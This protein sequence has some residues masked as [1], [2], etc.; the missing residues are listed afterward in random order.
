MRLCPCAFSLLQLQELAAA[1]S[2]G[3]YARPPLA[4]EGPFAHAPALS[5]QQKHELA[6]FVAQHESVQKLSPQQA[7]LTA[8]LA[9]STATYYSQCRTPYTLFKSCDLPHSSP[10]LTTSASR[11]AIVRVSF[12]QNGEQGVQWYYGILRFFAELC[13]PQCKV[14]YVDYFARAR[15][16][17][18]FLVQRVADKDDLSVRVVPIENLDC[19]VLL[20]PHAASGWLVVDAL[21]KLS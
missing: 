4:L 15:I 18:P 12:H 21:D 7:R 14:A 16:D 9:P 8:E 6:H 1:C 2:T 17:S 20:L 11:G 13:V 5:V 19:C 3:L 10:Q